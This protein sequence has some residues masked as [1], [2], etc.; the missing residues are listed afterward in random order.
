MSL[1]LCEKPSQAKDIAAVIGADEHRRNGYYEGGG[2]IVT[3]AFGHLLEMA[4]PGNCNKSWA[5]WDLNTL[6]M[7]PEKW[8]M[9]PKK[10]GLKQFKVMSDLIKQASSIV[11]ATDADREG[12]VIAREVMDACNYTGK[13]QRLWLSGLD[14]VSV[15][16]ALKNIKP[17]SETEPL[18][19]AGL[20]RQRADWLIGMNMTRAYTLLAQQTGFRGTLS[21]GRVQTPTLNI[22]ALRDKEIENFKSKDFFEAFAEFKVE[23]GTFIAKYQTPKNLLDDT[24]YCLNKDLLDKVVQDLNGKVGSI[25]QADVVQKSV[26]PTLLPDLSYLQELCSKLWGFSAKKTLDIA[27]SLYETH[28]ATTYPRTDCRHLPESQKTDINVILSNVEKNL[29]VVADSCRATNQS[30]NSRVFNDKEITAHHAII[31]TL[32]SINI[33]S[34]SAD[35]L[36][37]YELVCRHYIIQFYPN[38]TYEQ[39]T[40]MVS[41]DS[42][43]FKVTGKTELNKGWQA[44]LPQANKK[45]E[46]TLPQVSLGEQATY[47]GTNVQ[48]KKTKPPA[49]FTDGTLIA[50]MKSVAK[51]MDEPELKKVLKKTTGIGTNATR[52]NIIETLLQRGFL[53]KEKKYLISTKEGRSL[54]A[55]L[56]IEITNPVTTAKWEQALDSINNGQLNLN[57]F[58]TAQ[59]TWL[60]SMINDVKNGKT[61]IQ[62]EGTKVEQC[63]DCKANMIRIKSKKGK[64]FWVH[65]LKTNCETFITDDKGKLGNKIT[66]AIKSGKNCEKCGEPMLVRNINKGENKGKTFQGCSAYPKCKNTV[67]PK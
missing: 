61:T 64:H 3:W 29:P 60:T 16:T 45:N 23:N 11:I 33:N 48:S 10:S 49:R 21:V 18:Y 26:Q 40:I 65:A 24:G 1:Y 22:V 44:V 28:K 8:P 9:L 5:T 30:I 12:E 13:V 41:I 51:Y 19:F 2:N 38:Y 43:D 39:T 34:M 56:P 55:A 58:L 59:Q 37:V 46:I 62:I 6:P 4:S 66:K 52:A 42:H 67:W 57:D 17:G 63:P 15:E 20:G 27:Q 32:G 53:T 54:V 25:S 50:A 14:K 35:E 31:P 47:L 7:I 36:L